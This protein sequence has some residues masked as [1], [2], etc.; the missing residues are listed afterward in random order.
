MKLC[1]VCDQLQRLPEYSV[2]VSPG[3]EAVVCSE[4]K[5]SD[6]KTIVQKIMKSG[7]TGIESWDYLWQGRGVT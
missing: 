2:E 3:V 4:H 1:A 5:N 6:V 7:K